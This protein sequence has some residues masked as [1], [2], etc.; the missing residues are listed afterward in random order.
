MF[1]GRS[2][3]SCCSPAFMEW[4]LATSV[5]GDVTADPVQ[6]VVARS[7]KPRSCHARRLCGDRRV[8]ALGNRWRR[9]SARR[10]RRLFHLGGAWRR[11]QAQG[12]ARFGRELQRRDFE[13][14]EGRLIFA[15]MVAQ[16]RCELR[17]ANGATMADYRRALCVLLILLALIGG[18]GCCPPWSGP[19]FETDYSAVGA[20]VK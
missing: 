20:Q 7:G 13:A 15:K 3:L 14:C 2:G 16:S 12:A 11:E 10:E 6:L 8:A 19:P 4:P 9:A 18:A 17:N 5:C 1:S